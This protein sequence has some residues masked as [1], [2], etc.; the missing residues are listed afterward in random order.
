MLELC[1]QI[2]LINIPSIFSHYLLV[3]V[4]Q[5][6]SM[7]YNG[8]ATGL[9]VDTAGNLAQ[10]SRI[11]S[12]ERRITCSSGHNLSKPLFCYYF[13]S[14][15][16]ARRFYL[17]F[18]RFPILSRAFMLEK[19]RALT[20]N[21][22]DIGMIFFNT[23][24]PATT[25]TSAC[26]TDQE[27]REA[28]SCTTSRLLRP[29]GLPKS[30]F[31]GLNKV[32][33]SSQPWK[34]QRPR[35]GFNPSLD[36]TLRRHYATTHHVYLQQSFANCMLE[37]H[38]GISEKH[39][40][41]RYQEVL[42]SEQLARRKVQ[43]DQR[44]LTACA[45]IRFC[46]MTTP[47]LSTLGSSDYYSVPNIHRIDWVIVARIALTLAPITMDTTFISPSTC[48]HLWRPAHR[49]RKTIILHGLFPVIF[50]KRN[51]EALQGIASTHASCFG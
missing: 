12:H 17:E 16:G 44:L 39:L 5:G 13:A 27:R 37:Q 48:Y 41:E 10:R 42:K 51:W 2:D 49:A 29:S 3:V 4:A 28:Q 30:P 11:L 9:T 22:E 34:L 31:R 50:E 19:L 24:H 18:A 15:P 26:N 33:A 21:S 35:G 6:I 45:V 25:S 32:L 36:E 14:I 20:L 1:P 8:S 46:T 38:S 23:I 40:Q 7:L 47:P 43:T